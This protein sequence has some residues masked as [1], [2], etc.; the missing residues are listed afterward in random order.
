MWGKLAILVVSR[1]TLKLL[2]EH[3]LIGLNSPPK[4]REEEI[5]MPARGLSLS[6]LNQQCR[7]LRK[8]VRESAGSF[9]P[10]PPASE[11]GEDGQLS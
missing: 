7:V 4:K 6:L 9:P 8:L 2:A 3:L 1:E 11:G 10:H 5:V